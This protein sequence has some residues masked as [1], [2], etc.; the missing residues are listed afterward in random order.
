[1]LSQDPD[2]NIFAKLHSA[3]EG[4]PKSSVWGNRLQ[5]HLKEFVCSNRWLKKYL[6]SGD[7]SSC[8]PLMLRAL[9]QSESACLLKVSAARAREKAL[10]SER[11]RTD[12]GRLNFGS[13]DIF[14]SR[15]CVPQRRLLS[16]IDQFTDL[17]TWQRL[18]AFGI[19]FAA[20][21]AGFGILIS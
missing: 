2:S 1:M 20:V 6:T 10:P 7:F 4:F 14:A 8:K 21:N 17:S 15:K 19:F 18:Q 13:F 3:I 16:M 9:N 12:S 5:A 11:A